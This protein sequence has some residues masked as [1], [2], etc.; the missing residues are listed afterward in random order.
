MEEV[1]APVEAAKEEVVEEVAA[2]PV[3]EEAPEVVAEETPAPAAEVTV[4]DLTKVEGI[5]PKAAE[6]LNAKGINTFAELAKAD[7]ENIKTILTE[8]SS[9][10]AHLDPT[11]WPK[12]GQMAA[13]GNWDEL[14]AWQDSVKGGVE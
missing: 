6:A 1:A 7:P 9:R 12:Q 8:A 3:V 2:E 14:K 5:G 13:D 11:S 4:E 10:M